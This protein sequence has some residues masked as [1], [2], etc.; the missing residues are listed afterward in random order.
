MSRQVLDQA[1]EPHLKAVAYGRV[2]GTKHRTQGDGLNSQESRCREYARY[3]GYD[4]VEVFQDDTTGQ[5]MDR[6]GMEAMLEFLRKKKGEG[7]IVIIDDISR[8]A[9]NVETHFQLRKALNQ[10]DAKLESPSI[11]YG[12]DSDAILVEN[13]LASASLHQAQKNGEQTINRMR[14]RAMNGYYVFKAVIGYR[15]ERV[16]GHGKLLVRDEPIASIIQEAL[17]GYASGRFQM[18]VEVK[19]FLEAQEAYPKD[20]P[21][22]EIRNQRIYELLTRVLN[23]GYIEVPNWNV[24][25]R[26]GKHEGLISYTTFQK[27]QDRLNGMAKAPAR[28]DINADFPL[29]GF[30]LC[31]DC[32]KPLT[33]RWSK[34]K[35]GKR[36]PYYLC[37]NKACV[38]YRK[39]IR[40][41]VLEADFE[42]LLKGLQPTKGLFK[43]AKAMFH[44]AWEMRLTQ[45]SEAAKSF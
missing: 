21:N 26:E 38:S 9:R 11:E 7:Y 8:L 33:A 42:A 12:E 25:P 5:I 37:P 44:D 19:G 14:G 18:H 23:A 36:H 4:I 13:L 6:P 30:I 15:F 41:D 32:Q 22:G 29:R 1:S 28:Q 34:S 17:E 43:V 40:R 45:A 2:S 39:S 31:D 10:V 24:P 16:P 3:K 35:T 27:I 20:L